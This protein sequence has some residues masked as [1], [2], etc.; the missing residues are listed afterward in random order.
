MRNPEAGLHPDKS[1]FAMTVWLVIGN[2][3]SE[4]SWEKKTLSGYEFTEN[5][6]VYLFA[7]MPSWQILTARE[8]GREP[9][10]VL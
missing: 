2:T 6:F 8:V 10:F 9:G 1:G 7:S 4:D 3:C 5:V